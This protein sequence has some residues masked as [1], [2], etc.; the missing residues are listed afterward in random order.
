MIFDRDDN[1]LVNAQEI[2]ACIGHI[3]SDKEQEVCDVLRRF[4]D[5]EGHINYK[6]MVSKL[7]A[8]GDQ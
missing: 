2:I 1:S 6:E 8:E 7:L 4:E 5:A 3:G